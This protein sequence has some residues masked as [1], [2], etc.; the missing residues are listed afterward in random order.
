MREALQ[1]GGRGG[2]RRA[3]GVLDWTVD[4]AFV[5]GVAGRRRGSSRLLSVPQIVLP[6][7][8]LFAQ[9]LLSDLRFDDVLVRRVLRRR[10]VQRLQQLRKEGG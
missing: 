4:E 2:Q 3:G 10:R 9:L 1:D 6:T 8:L 5:A 7:K